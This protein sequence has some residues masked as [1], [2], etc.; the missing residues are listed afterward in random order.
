MFKWP[1]KDEKLQKIASKTLI[2]FDCNIL[3]SDTNYYRGVTKKEEDCTFLN[4]INT[5]LFL[6]VDVLVLHIVVYKDRIRLYS[7]ITKKAEKIID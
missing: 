4:I 3:K 7:A 5:W 6:R 2:F 1:K